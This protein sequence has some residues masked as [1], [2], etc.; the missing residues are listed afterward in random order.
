MG[1][2]RI[3]DNVKGFN[4]YMS[5]TGAYLFEIDE[6]TGLLNWQR[7]GISEQIA[8]AWRSKCSFWIG[9]LYPKYS[10]IDLRTKTVTAQ[11]RGFRRAFSKF[12]N[13]VLEFITWG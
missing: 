1:R 6:T 12:G 7:L 2:T 3:P 10:S 8:N 4:S 13:P 5:E 11:A 9:T